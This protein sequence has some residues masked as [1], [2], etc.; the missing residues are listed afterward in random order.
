MEN[1]LYE[2]A[3][4]RRSI[5]RYTGE[6]VDERIVDEILKTAL[7]APSSWGR[8]PVEFVVVRE[9]DII[10]KIAACKAMG[11]G[12]L[13]YA[14]VA[15]IVMVDT[16]DCE[17]WIEDGAVASS[18]LLLAAEQYGIGACWIHIR[19]RAGQRGTA[20]EE[21]RALLGIPD[22]YSVL[23]VVALGHKGEVK[24]PYEDKDLCIGNIHREMF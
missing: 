14:D 8:H 20:D 16:S 12:S 6:K 17:L 3:R 11:A 21:I 23:N 22:R 15:V 5:R 10:R 9:K 19:G 13:P 7:T 4:K 2:L 24:S 18:Y 1:A